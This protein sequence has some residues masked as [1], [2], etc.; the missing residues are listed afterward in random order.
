MLDVN[1]EAQAVS[2]EFGEAL[3]A[4]VAARDT[5]IAALEARLDSLRNQ[6]A[7][8][9]ALQRQFGVGEHDDEHNHHDCPC[10]CHAIVASGR[11]ASEIT[12]PPSARV[13]L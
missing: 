4:R 8:D 7:A 13:S 5:D 6:Q 11:E 12:D 3:K 1:K 9:D 2:I 10:D